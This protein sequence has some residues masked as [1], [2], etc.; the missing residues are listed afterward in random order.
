MICIY[1]INVLNDIFICF[2]Q[3]YN[4]L[5]INIRFKS[6]MRSVTLGLCCFDAINFCFCYC[7]LVKPCRDRCFTPW[8][9]IKWVLKI[10]II[11]TTVHLIREKKSEWE[12]AF[13]I[14]SLD[15]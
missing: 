2:L 14:G 6:K 10:I 12:D 5:L 8:S 13:D 15:L 11:G 3:Y 9:I 7:F 4:N 1:N